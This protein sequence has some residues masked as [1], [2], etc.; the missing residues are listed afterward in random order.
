LARKG[1]RFYSAILSRWISR[2]PI[3]E[4]G[5]L[6]TYGFVA[7]APIGLFDSYGLAWTIYRN[8]DKNWA[9]ATSDDEMDLFS[10]LAMKIRLDWGERTKWLRKFADGSFVKEDEEASTCEFYQGP[11]TV[12]VYISK[13]IGWDAWF[14]STANLFRNRAAENGDRYKAKRYKVVKYDPGNSDPDFINAWNTDGIYAFA[15]GGHGVGDD[16]WGWEGYE[17]TSGTG[18]GV[19]PYDMSPPYRLQAVCTCLWYRQ[20]YC[21]W[22]RIHA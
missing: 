16:V 5:G 6:N 22:R 10:D 13:R 20:S 18:A 4:R 1:L 21:F 19:S 15:F 8:P 7:N 9:L 11:N 3:E 14:L 12:I 2:D 17:A